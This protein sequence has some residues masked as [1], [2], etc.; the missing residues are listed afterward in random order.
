MK[1][2][3]KK[4]GD[5]KKGLK[6]VG[7]RERPQGGGWEERETRPRLGVALVDRWKRKSNKAKLSQRGQISES[8]SFTILFVYFQF[9]SCVCARASQR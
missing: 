9:T 6:V 7:R 3:R 1:S 5:G 8:S 2:Q 4:V